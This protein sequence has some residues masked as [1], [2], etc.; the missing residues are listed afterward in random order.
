MWYA[1]SGLLNN[2]IC[3]HCPHRH[4]SS[5]KRAVSANI[6]KLIKAK[7]HAWCYFKSTYSDIAKHSFKIISVITR[8]AIGSFYR[9]KDLKVLQSKKVK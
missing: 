8:K 7:H 3:H 2:V 5:F 9:N 1:F 6:M 4:C